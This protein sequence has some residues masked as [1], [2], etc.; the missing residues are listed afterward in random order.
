MSDDLYA[1][2]LLGLLLIPVVGTAWG[3]YRTYRMLHPKREDQAI[4]ESR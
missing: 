3:M 1:A 2:A 4:D